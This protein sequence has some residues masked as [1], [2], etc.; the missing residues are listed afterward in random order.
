MQSNEKHKGLKAKHSEWL[1][2]Y[3]FVAPILI[4]M[5]VWFYYPVISTFRFSL[6]D[7]NLLNLDRAKFIGLK[8]YFDVLKD[9]SF[10]GSLKI[11][12]QLTIIAVPI[13]SFIALIIAVNLNKIIK[14]KAFFRTLYYMPYIT[15]TIAVTTVFMFLFVENGLATKLF[16]LIGLPNVTWH[17]DM[18]M[19]LPF[20]A[21][22]C[23]W[24]YIGFYVVVFLSGLQTIPNEIYE[25]CDVDGANSFQK[26]W[27]ITV[28]MLRPTT[29]LV[30]LSGVIFVLQ[31]FDQ[32]YALA[33]GG[34]LGY[35][36][37]AT[38]TA[39]IFFYSEAFKFYKAG[40]GSASAFIVFLIIMAVTVIQKVFL[41]KEDGV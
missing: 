2:G 34:S 23:I 18:K 32:P 11:S 15:S 28:P 41:D 12:A 37:G 40:Y 21:V 9:D 7:A 33:R 29:F 10:W 14:G 5:A 27:R 36:A 22:I 24:T 25:A 26:F 17:S 35:P 1:T 13:Q 30:I 6:T 19:A 4:L 20:L 3:L 38:S 8:N 31:F 16:T 39:T